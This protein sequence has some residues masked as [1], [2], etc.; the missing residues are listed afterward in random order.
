MPFM[1]IYNNIDGLHMFTKYNVCPPKS[2]P[3]C[4]NA[5]YDKFS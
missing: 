2:S 5:M 1:L 4:E 3:D